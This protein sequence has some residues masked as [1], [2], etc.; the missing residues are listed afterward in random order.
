MA[1]A[2]P[3][4]T[5][6]ERRHC[7]LARKGV[8]AEARRGAENRLRGAGQRT[9]SACIGASRRRERGELARARA[10]R[11]WP[12]RHFAAAPLLLSARA[13]TAG[14]QLRASSAALRMR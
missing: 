7:T 11:T 1:A 13:S 8:P 9:P 14:R 2:A 12:C 3:Q 6:S 4:E 5:R 10:G